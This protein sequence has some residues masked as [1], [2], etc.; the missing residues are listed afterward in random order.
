MTSKYTKYLVTLALCVTIAACG[1]EDRK[2][3]RVG[4]K[5]FAENLILAEMIAQMAENAGIP[6]ERNIPYGLTPKLMEA[7]KQDFIDVYPEY[8]GTSLTFLGQAPTADG[9]AS[10]ERVQALFKPLGLEMTGKFGFSN[11]YA[12][13]MTRERAKELGVST[14]QNLTNV[15]GFTYVVD[16]DFVQ[17]PADGLQQMNRRYGINGANVVTHPG[18][19]E[20]KDKIV[21]TLL[22][23]HYTI[24]SIN[25]VFADYDYLPLQVEDIH[26]ILQN[27]KVRKNIGGNLPQYDHIYFDL[28]LV[29]LERVRGVKVLVVNRPI[30]VF[31]PH[32]LYMMKEFPYE[33][34]NA[35]TQ[36][37]NVLSKNY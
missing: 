8:N 23:L 10:T 4:A 33:E 6:V 29:V 31:M 19:T 28:F 26:D 7:V 1:G 34:N 21:S 20:G 11:D 27:D 37:V 5:P 2:S 13:V 18:G 17:R 9:N 25:Q 14:I 15:S 3:L 35:T 30:G 12:L 24:S 22:A 36:F 32:E 16:D